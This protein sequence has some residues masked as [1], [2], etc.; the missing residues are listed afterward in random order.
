MEERKRDMSLRAS[1]QAGSILEK[2]GENRM[3]FQG[4]G[5][6]FQGL[7]ELQLYNPMLEASSPGLASLF[8]P[9]LQAGVGSEGLSLPTCKMGLSSFTVIPVVCFMDGCEKLSRFTGRKPR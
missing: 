7:E 1:D 9:G 8:L 6:S 5:L 3:I 4:I 2:T